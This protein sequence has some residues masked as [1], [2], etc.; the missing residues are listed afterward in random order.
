MEVNQDLTDITVIRVEYQGTVLVYVGQASPGS[1]EDAELWNIKKIFYDG[2]G[3]VT[4]TGFANGNV[5]YQER[6][7]QRATYTYS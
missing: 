5:K 2:N 3:N 1:D 4:K 6:W 7:S